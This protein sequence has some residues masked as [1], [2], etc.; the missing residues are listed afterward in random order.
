MVL[1][2]VAGGAGFVVLLSVNGTRKI[3]AESCVFEVPKPLSF[4][5][6]VSGSSATGLQALAES[7]GVGIPLVDS[8]GPTVVP[9]DEHSAP[10]IV[11][12]SV[13]E[14]GRQ[15]LSRIAPTL[16]SDANGKFIAVLV[17]DGE[18]VLADSAIG[19]LKAARQ[20]RAGA[21]VY[22]EQVGAGYAFKLRT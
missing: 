2:T 4:E 3:S 20:R 17:G 7:L 10:G 12:S 18:F 11:R 8:M 1:R 22:V 16:G 21:Q 9:W 13:G 5:I 19:A 15:H 14:R 6:S